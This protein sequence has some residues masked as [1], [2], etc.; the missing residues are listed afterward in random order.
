MESASAAVGE[1]PRRPPESGG[2]PKP[3]RIRLQSCHL[4]HFYFNLSNTYYYYYLFSLSPRR[5]ALQTIQSAVTVEVLPD[6]Q[7]PAHLSTRAI[8]CLFTLWN[9]KYS[10]V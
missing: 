5:Y 7:K 10:R 6:G 4:D 8:L 9:M 1:G 2:E 3:R